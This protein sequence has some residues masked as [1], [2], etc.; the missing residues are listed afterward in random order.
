MST[1]E[2]RT[3]RNVWT[4]KIWDDSIYQIIAILQERLHIGGVIT[5]PAT[6]VAAYKEQLGAAGPELTFLQLATPNKESP[7]RWEPTTRLMELVAQRKTTGEAKLLYE[8]DLFY[9]LLIDYVFGY[10]SKAGYGSA[11]TRELLLALGLL[12]EKDGDDWVTADLHLL[13]GNAYFAKRE[14]DGLVFSPGIFPRPYQ[15]VARPRH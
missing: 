8:A 13:F 4:K 14:Q 11:F 10:K 2:T 6:F 7:F 1:N 5:H 15:F 3:Q 12:R 9:Q